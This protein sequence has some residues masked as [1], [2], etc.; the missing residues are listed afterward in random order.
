MELVY[1]TLA[2]YGTELR[3]NKGRFTLQ[4]DK[5]SHMNR[6]LGVKPVR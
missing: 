6:A 4:K 2:S 1:L 3:M 5:C